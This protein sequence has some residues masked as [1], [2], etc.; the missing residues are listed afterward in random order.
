MSQ[1]IHV[2][3]HAD[4]LGGAQTEVLRVILTPQGDDGADCK[5]SRHSAEGQLDGGE[6]AGVVES[7]QAAA[8]LLHDASQVGVLC[9]QRSDLSSIGLGSQGELGH[10]DI[11]DNDGEDDVHQDDI[12]H[13]IAH[14]EDGAL[15]GVVGQ[16]GLSR[17][18]DDALAGVANDVDHVD[19]DEHREPDTHTHLGDEVEHHEG[20][21]EHDDLTQNDEGTV[22]TELTVGLINCHAHERVGDTV[23][24]THDG[25]DGTGQHGCQ[26]DDTDQEV[27]D[28][29]HH[30]HVGVGGGVIQSVH[31]DL[32]HFRSVDAVF[33]KRLFDL[34]H[35]EVLLSILRPVCCHSLRP[36]IRSPVGCGCHIAN[37]GI[38]CIHYEPFLKF[39]LVKF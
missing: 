4:L 7:G 3:L 33:F 9:H 27:A 6:Q 19:D 13:R 39:L 11:G 25:D 30:H 31:H 18:G 38:L 15:L 22:L 2:V 36:F 34:C 21:D 12:V 24:D 16:A 26:T 29:T 35:R 28:I 23:P 1:S 32:P 5:D 20:G 14:C 37:R 8:R 17:L 10:Q